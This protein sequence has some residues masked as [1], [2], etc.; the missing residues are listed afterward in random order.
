MPRESPERADPGI[1]GPETVTFWNRAPLG[2]DGS[3]LNPTPRA[4]APWAIE[5]R[6]LGA[7]A[8]RARWNK[9][10]IRIDNSKPT[11]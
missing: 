8:L 1:A 2:L 4:D 9:N 5:S 7:V 6:P 10:A 11:A 3:F